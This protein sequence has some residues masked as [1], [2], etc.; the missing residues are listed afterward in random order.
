MLRILI[1]LAALL[2]GIPAHHERS[3]G[4]PDHGQRHAAGKKNGLF[5]FCFA[6]TFPFTFTFTLAFALAFTLTL[7]LAATHF[8]CTGA[9]RIGVFGNTFRVVTT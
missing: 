9:R 7:T 2:V 5:S 4:N 1:R 8:M 3:A 6:F